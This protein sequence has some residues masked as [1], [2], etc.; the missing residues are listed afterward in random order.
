VTPANVQALL[1]PED[2]GELRKAMAQFAKGVTSYEAEFRIRRPD[3]AILLVRRDG[4]RD[5]RQG[6]SGR[7][8]QRR[9]H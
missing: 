7:A 6:R 4:R 3:G 9:Y 8:R 5:R 2:I 1:H